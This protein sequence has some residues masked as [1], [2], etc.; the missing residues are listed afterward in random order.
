MRVE[1]K[2]LKLASTLATALACLGAAAAQATPLPASAFTYNVL[3]GGIPACAVGVHSNDGSCISGPSFATTDGGTGNNTGTGVSSGASG[4]GVS[5]LA[6]M[7]Y[8]FEVGGPIAP[9]VPG[10]QPGQIAVDILSSGAASLSGGLGMSLATL[11]I[12]DAGSDADIAGGVPDPDPGVP[13]DSRFFGV[14]CGN[15]GCTTI[16]AAWT[17]STQ[18]GAGFTAPDHLCLTQGDMYKIVITASTT[19]TDAGASGSASVDPK[20]IVDPS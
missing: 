17:Q 2:N 11:T 1:N 20:I 14:T 15:S 9:A 18:I 16:G 6:T 3:N 7:T 5:S 19:A 12:T 4:P 8:Y 10:G 13:L